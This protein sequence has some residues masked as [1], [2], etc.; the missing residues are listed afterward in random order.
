MRP[1]VG[2][3]APSC[4]RQ[5][6]GLLSHVESFLPQ[7]VLLL[8][9]YGM[10][11]S[12]RWLEL[13]FPTAWQ[14]T[15]SSAFCQPALHRFLPW[16]RLTFVM[17][18]DAAQPGSD[19]WR[20]SIVP[21]T[22]P[23]GRLRRPSASDPCGV[24]CCALSLCRSRCV[25]L[26]CPGLLGSCSLVCTLRVLCCVCGVPGHLS[27]VHRCARSVCLPWGFFLRLCFCFFCSLCFLP[28]SFC[29]VPSSFSFC[30]FF[31]FLF[32][33][34]PFFLKGGNKMVKGRANTKSTGMGNWSSS[35]AMLCSPLCWCLS[36]GHAPGMR[37]A[38]LDV[39]GRGLVWVR[40][41]VSARR[42]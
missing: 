29:L 41:G 5:L 28:S 34:I 40:L 13:R 27:P 24:V 22:G 36:G 31:A 39:H 3:N 2:S 6:W 20:W 10:I 18:S 35:A 38:C 32:L 4:G 11:A 16:L 15:H 23:A 42:G 33:R 26:R 19:Q 9:V 25:G 8:Q 1:W 37:H 7:G 17:V 12:P 30:L 21:A 14:G